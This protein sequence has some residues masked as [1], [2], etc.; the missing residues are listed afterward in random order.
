M[1]GA[2]CGVILEEDA[3]HK[4]SSCPSRVLFG[5]WI[6]HCE[7]LGHEEARSRLRYARVA[8]QIAE[9]LKLRLVDSHAVFPIPEV[10]ML[11]QP[12]NKV[13]VQ[14][15]WNPFCKQFNDRGCKY[16]IWTERILLLDCV[17][18]TSW[19]GTRS[20]IQCEL[21]Q[22][23]LSSMNR[24]GNNRLLTNGPDVWQVWWLTVG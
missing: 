9:A 17:I 4:A 24:P 23:C 21:V 12:G 19:E 2:T 11:A 13:L 5:S 1:R 18:F 16:A 14:V 10:E 15:D 22:S 8:T 6:T 20:K 7:T 3:E